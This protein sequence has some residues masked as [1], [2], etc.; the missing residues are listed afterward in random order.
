MTRITRMFCRTPSPALS[1]RSLVAG[2]VVACA[3]GLLV[4]FMA[5]G[6]NQQVDRAP[7][8]ANLSQTLPQQAMMCDMVGVGYLNDNLGTQAVI[9]VVSY[10]LGSPG[11]N[12]I[13]VQVAGF[14]LLPTIASNTLC[15]FMASTN[16]WWNAATFEGAAFLSWSF[17]TNRP[18]AGTVYNNWSVVYPE[19]SI[20]PASVENGV[21]CTFIS[22]LVHASRIQPNS[23]NFYDLVCAGS[24]STAARVCRDSRSYVFFIRQYLPSN[25]VTIVDGV[26]E[27]TIRDK[28]Q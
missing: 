17:A 25:V 23:T 2:R 10:W 24:T 28:Q 1:S 8:F 6:G 9:D 11:T 12:R 3:V 22:N 14:S 18:L 19:K 20:F 7:W 15:V 5:E 13:P 16:D 4:V 27:Q 21:V 26:I